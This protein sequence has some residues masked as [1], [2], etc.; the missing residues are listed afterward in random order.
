M[1]FV[2]IGVLV[3]G[4][5][6]LEPVTGARPDAGRQVALEITDAG[7]VALAPSIGPSIEQLQGRVVSADSA[8]YVIAVSQVKS[9]RGDVTVWR[10]E[11]VRISTPF[12]ARAYFREFSRTRTLAVTAVAVTALGLLAT[13]GFRQFFPDGPDVEDPPGSEQFK[14]RRRPLAL[15]PTV[16][17]LTP[18]RSY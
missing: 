16:L 10:G 1:T 11:A 6:S 18:P 7:R 14:G 12:I 2:G 4:C 5:F 13:K 17:R 8:E 15:P 3:A 9:I